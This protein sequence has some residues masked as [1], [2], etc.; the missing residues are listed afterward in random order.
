MAGNKSPFTGAA[1]GTWNGDEVKGLDLTL[2]QVDTTDIADFEMNITKTFPNTL[3]LVPNDP[4]NDNHT[5]A[6]NI[7]WNRHFVYLDGTG[8][9]IGPGTTNDGGSAPF[10]AYVYWQG[11][12]T[13]ITAEQKVELGLTGAGGGPVNDTIGNPLR[14]LVYSGNYS[15]SL[16]HPAGAE[17]FD[18]V[19]GFTGGDHI[20][21]RNSDGIA[22]PMWHSFANALIGTAMIENAAIVNA[23]INDVSADKMTAGTIFGHEISIGQGDEGFGS[24][25][26]FDF[27]AFPAGTPQQGF[28]ISGDGSFMFRD[29]VGGQLSFGD[30]GLEIRADLRLKDGKTISLV[31]LH[32]E[33]N[34]FKYNKN[35]D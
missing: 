4:F 11:S 23:T 22:T 19:P 29:D 2:G 5:S 6:G 1:A 8:Y 35:H 34:V 7:S 30:D 26:S 28:V 13:E 31:N 25:K 20:I 21:A 16:R 12:T 27:Q 14:N 18:P 9:V 24:I 32:A 10:D 3:A 15:P 33:P 17:G